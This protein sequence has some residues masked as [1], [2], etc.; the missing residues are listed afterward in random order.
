MLLVYSDNYLVEHAFTPLFETE[1]A[2]PGQW[3]DPTRTYTDSSR[4]RAFPGWRRISVPTG[5]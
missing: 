3:P 4:D 2:L 5:I 1:A